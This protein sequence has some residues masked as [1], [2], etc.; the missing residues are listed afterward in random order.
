MTLF[1]ISIAGINKAAS[2]GQFLQ[3][4]KRELSVSGPSTEFPSATIWLEFTSRP[5]NLE[6]SS[7]EHAVASRRSQVAGHRSLPV[8]CH[9][10]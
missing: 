1:V 7:I 3:G 5:L 9:P 4:V 8:S 2:G 6:T 10:F